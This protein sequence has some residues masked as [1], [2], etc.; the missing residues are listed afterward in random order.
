M[1]DPN[2]VMSVLDLRNADGV[3]ATMLG[4]SG[5]YYENPLNEWY[6]S[7]FDKVPVW[8]ELEGRP[9]LYWNT[10]GDEH[11]QGKLYEHRFSN[12]IHMMYPTDIK[13]PE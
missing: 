10:T 1:K 4:Y 3:L 12:G 7:F 5:I 11:F 9:G 2:N 13:W 6:G 8:K